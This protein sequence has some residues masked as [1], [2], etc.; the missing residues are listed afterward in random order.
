MKKRLLIL[1][2]FVIFIISLV[3][4]YLLLHYFDPYQNIVM[5]ISFIIIIFLLLSTSFFT[6]I[7]YFIKK[8]YYRWEVFL[9]HVI[10]SFRQSFLLS[11]YI[12]WLVYFYNLWTP[13]YLTWFL[14]MITILFLELL[15]KNLKD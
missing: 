11:I 4:F 6:I 2:L 13:V 3:T 12:L 9:S 14:L 15:L 1:I 5:W 10:I 7:L 8:V